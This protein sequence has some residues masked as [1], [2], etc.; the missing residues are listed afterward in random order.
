MRAMNKRYEKIGSPA[1]SLHKD[2]TGSHSS[3]GAFLNFKA[4]SKILE[5]LIKEFPD[6]CQSGKD[7]QKAAEI[8]ENAISEENKK[9]REAYQSLFAD[10]FDCHRFHK[11]VLDDEHL[12]DYNNNCPLGRSSAA[13]EEYMKKNNIPFD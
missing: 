11:N 8:I 3:G 7:K 2:R 10:M 13:V 9:Y 4:M 12:R 5:D 1:A 6:F